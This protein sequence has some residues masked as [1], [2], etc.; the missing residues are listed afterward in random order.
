MMIFDE[1]LKII[2]DAKIIFD[3][4]QKNHVFLFNQ[5]LEMMK[6]ENDGFWSCFDDFS[7]L[8]CENDENWWKL[9]FFEN[10]WCD[11]N[12]WSF[13]MKNEFLISQFDFVIQTNFD[14]P[15]YF[16]IFVCLTVGLMLKWPLFCP[17]MGIFWGRFFL[18]ILNHDN[19]AIFHEKWETFLPSNP[20]LK[21]KNVINYID[22]GC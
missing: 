3:D 1:I 18:E 10:I 22:F 2:I 9:R 17:K 8:A 12:I 13:L 5:K 11:E 4:F 19:L 15:P 16:E 20:L 7:M 14:R 21:W 6:N